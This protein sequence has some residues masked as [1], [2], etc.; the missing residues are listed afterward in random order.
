MS[1]ASPGLN[2]LMMSKLT[3]GSLCAWSAGCVI[4]DYW[5]KDIDKHVEWTATWP[6]TSGEISNKEALILFTGLTGS[7]FLIAASMPPLVWKLGLLI[8]PVVIAYPKFKRF[9]PMP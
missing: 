1:L 3:A 5:D 8:S 9:F 7:C 6:L 4:N 2:L